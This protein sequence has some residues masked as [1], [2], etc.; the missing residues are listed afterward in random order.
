MASFFRTTWVSQ[1][2]KG[3]TNLDLNKERDDEVLGAVALAGLQTTCT[4]LQTDNY[5][6]TSSLNY[7]RPDVLSD[8]KPTVS[9]H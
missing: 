5:T 2:Q 1:Y 6:N 8:A 4:S 3:K 7:Y 9:V